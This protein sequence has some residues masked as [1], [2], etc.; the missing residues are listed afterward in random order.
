M[1]RSSDIPTFCI[2]DRKHHVMSLD[3]VRAKAHV[4]EPKRGQQ[5]SKR[6]NNIE[7]ASRH[8]PDLLSKSRA[9]PGRTLAVTSDNEESHG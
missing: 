3:I 1:R 7:I 9:V 4:V 5:C 8:L 6:L 2:K